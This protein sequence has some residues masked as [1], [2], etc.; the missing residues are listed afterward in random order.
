MHGFS[1]GGNEGYL[2][3]Y[4]PKLTS[5]RARELID[6]VDV[7]PTIAKYLQNVDIPYDSVGMARNFYGKGRFRV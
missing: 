4:N 1:G 6:V 2:M 5:Y 7:A 3:F